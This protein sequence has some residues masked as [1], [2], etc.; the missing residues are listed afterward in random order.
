M[1]RAGIDTQHIKRII[2]HK[3]DSMFERYHIIDED[4]IREAGRKAERFVREQ[5]DIEESETKDRVQ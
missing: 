5:H 2:G 1:R 3:S 4:D